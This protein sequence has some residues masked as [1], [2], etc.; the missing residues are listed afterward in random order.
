MPGFNSTNVDPGAAVGVTVWPVASK[1]SPNTG[2]DDKAVTAAAAITHMQNPIL[3]FMRSPWLN[4]ER[5]GR[6]QLKI[7]RE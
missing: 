7:A 6:Y 5:G 4:L 1:V 3:V 2:A